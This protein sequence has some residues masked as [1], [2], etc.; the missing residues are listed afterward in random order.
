LSA[1]N[2][3]SGLIEEAPEQNIGYQS[4]YYYGSKEQDN[5]F[6]CPHSSIKKLRGRDRGNDLDK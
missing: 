1:E 4:Q 6:H 3:A 2:P 5:W